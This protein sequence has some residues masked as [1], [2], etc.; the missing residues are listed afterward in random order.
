MFILTLWAFLIA[1]HPGSGDVH[2][3]KIAEGQYASRQACWEALDIAI[4]E[5]KKSHWKH[6]GGACQ[7]V[8]GKK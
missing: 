4:A 5:S 1:E 3:I 8:K 7:P 6:V 2:K